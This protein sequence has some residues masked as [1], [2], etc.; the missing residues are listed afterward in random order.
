MDS[1]GAGILEGR[2]GRLLVGGK[3]GLV[4]VIGLVA[5]GLDIGLTGGLDNGLP[6]DLASGLLGLG[7]GGGI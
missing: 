5:G 4:S 1:A 6:G 2:G 7:W 3:G